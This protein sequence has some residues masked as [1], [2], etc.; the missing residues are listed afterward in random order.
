LVAREAETEILPFA[1]REGIGVI[2]YSPMGAGLLTGRMTRERATSLPEDDWRKRNI[3][4]Q[5]PR[6]SRN[7]EMVELL[8]QIGQRHGRTPGEV[9]IAWTLKN[10]AVTAAIVG[11]RRADQVPGIAGALDFRLSPEE[12][13]EIDR[14]QAAQ[15]ASA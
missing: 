6:L 5:E 10:P 7:L 15:S 11:I 2:V 8:R 13:K 3:E 12:I 4:F 14:F 9:A 1:E